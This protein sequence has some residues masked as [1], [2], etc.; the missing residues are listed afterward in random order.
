MDQ[1]WDMIV[2]L[3][4]LGGTLA[5]LITVWW[6]VSSDNASVRQ[7]V[8]NNRREFILYKDTQMKSEEKTLL[9]ITTKAAC[10]DLIKVAEIVDAM[11]KRVLLHHEDTK[12]HRTEDFEQRITSLIKSVEEFNRTN[13]ESHEKIMDMIRGLSK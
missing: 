10:A 11:E 8:E 5:S 3:L 1:K 6:K 4:A 13:T 9:L 2:A 7:T 12:R